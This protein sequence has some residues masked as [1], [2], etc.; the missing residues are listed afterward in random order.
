VLVTG[1]IDLS[2]GSMMGLAAVLFGAATIGWHLPV[3]FAVVIALG[4]GLVGGALNGILVSRLAIPPLIVT[5]GTL[6]LFRGI[7]EGLTHGAVNYSGFPAWFLFFG[8]GYLGG[9]IPAQLPLFVVVVCA[10]W[11]LL[12]RSVVGR[13]WYAIGFSPAVPGTPDW[14]SLPDTRLAYM[15][16][17]LTASLAAIIYV[18][19]LGQAKSDAGTG[20]EL[21]A[22]TAA[23]LGGTSV[24]GGRG[25]I[26][27]TLLGLAA[28]STLQNGLHLAALPSELD[29]PGHRGAADSDNRDRSDNRGREGCAT[30]GGV[31]RSGNRPARR[32]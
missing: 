4:A 32:K 19:H 26:A 28:L 24:F 6:S 22:I 11:L 25:T 21:D 2:V 9:V 15:L 3:A 5:L 1:G 14:R 17:G 23:V 7:A 30:D 12:H 16:S 8:Q 13:A 31:P 10:F 20:Y 29:G 27:G 18:S